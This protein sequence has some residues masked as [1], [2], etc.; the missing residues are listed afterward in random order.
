MAKSMVHWNSNEVAVIDVETTGLQAGYHEIIQIAIVMLD[1]N[2]DVR[3]DVMPFQLKLKPDHPERVAK[4]A[5]RVNGLNLEDLMAK[6]I[7]QVEAVDL[8]IQWYESLDIPYNKSG[9]N[10]CKIIPLGQ[11]YA[12][13]KGFIQS[14][15]GLETYDRY[16]HY[17]HRDT[18]IAAHF[19]NDCYAMKAE[20]VPFAKTNLKWLCK[21]LNITNARAHD[22]L[23]DCIATAQVYKRLTTTQAILL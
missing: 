21:K 16:F 7:P 9:Y 22:A 12:F 10:Q 17:H 5:M 23:Q 2:F 15:L 6:G 18:M 20:D 1:S 3:T 8:F 13:D 14:W 19:V 4:Q 11:N